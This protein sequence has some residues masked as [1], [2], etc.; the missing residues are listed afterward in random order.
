MVAFRYTGPFRC[1]NQACG[2]VWTANFVTSFTEPVH[3]PR[4][5]LF[6]PKC[7]TSRV[8]Q[9]EGDIWVNRY[10][11]NEGKESKEESSSETPEESPSETPE[12]SSSETPEESAK[13][14]DVSKYIS[15]DSLTFDE[16]EKSFDS[17]P[18]EEPLSTENE[19][20]E[21]AK[22]EGG[23]PQIVDNL[24]DTSGALDVTYDADD[25]ADIIIAIYEA[26]SLAMA[27]LGKNISDIENDKAKRG[28]RALARI[29]KRHPDLL[30]GKWG[31]IVDG[32]IVL[33]ILGGP[34][35]KVGFDELRKYLKK[36][37]DEKTKAT[38]P[39]SDTKRVSVEKE[40]VTAKEPAPIVASAKA[41][42]TPAIVPYEGEYDIGN[43]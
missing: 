14:S 36:R 33:S 7:R 5:V 26:E 16:P 12:E 31:D 40:P 18:D 28:G 10:R 30:K 8:K 13:E 23:I 43:V 4:R 1:Q 2:N 42:H 17:T 41:P 19:S 24:G 29:F 15:K 11:Q 6:C 34:I 9:I 27:G 3:K 25:C 22:A 35:A 38:T 39:K 20:H 37:E 32:L 21:D